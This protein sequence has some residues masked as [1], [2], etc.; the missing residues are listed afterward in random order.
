MDEQY[1]IEDEIE[2]TISAY[3]QDAILEGNPFLLT[4]IQ[5]HMKQGKYAGA[6]L[7]KAVLRTNIVLII[8]LLLINAATL[9]YYFNSSKQTDISRQLLNNLRE[10]FQIEQSQYEL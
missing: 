4:R 5:E 1:L 2:K 3:D 8:F 6:R 9:F 7:D 10:E